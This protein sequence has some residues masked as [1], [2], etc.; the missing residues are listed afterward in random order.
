MQ[1]MNPYLPLDTYIPDGEPHVFGDRLY[2]Y[3]SHDREGGD[4]YCMDPYEVFSAPIHDLGH[5]KSHGISYRITQ[6]PHAS[7]SR[8]QMYA[9]DVVQGNDGRYYMYYCLSGAQGKGGYD[10]PISVAVADEPGGPF[11]YYGDVKNADGSLFRKYVL[12]DPAVINDQGV[13]RLYYGALIPFEEHINFLNRGMMYRIMAKTYGKT[14]EEVKKEK[15]A[16]AGAITVTLADDMVTVISQ[17]KRILPGIAKGSP[18]EGHGFFEASSIRKIRDTYY[19]IYSSQ[20]NHE[21]CYATSK[22]PDRDFT[23]RGVIISN[24][25]I[26][27]EGRKPEDRLNH[28][29]NNHGSLVEVDGQY[30][31]FYHRMTHGNDYS[32]QGCAE[33][34]EILADGTIPQVEMTSQGLNGKPL[35]A[36]GTYPAGIYCNLSNGHMPHACNR[37]EVSQIPRLIHQDGEQFLTDLQNDVWVGYKYFACRDNQQITLTYRS[38]TE[39]SLEISLSYQGKAVGRQILPAAKRWQ[40]I[41][42]PVDISDGEHALYFHFQGQGKV[43]FLKFTW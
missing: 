23:Y 28:T 9:P 16:I 39:A 43:E 2:V 6:D 32:R 30:Y 12:F 7:E 37:K 19:F 20:V 22:Y 25:D 26:G 40:S 14:Y 13:I 31:I 36:E 42:L 24:G 5:W 41:S 18:M 3:G 35:L 11:T 8:Q 38:E 21:L 15:G 1:A 33:K 29:G 34:V 17:P 10:G 4:T 27:L